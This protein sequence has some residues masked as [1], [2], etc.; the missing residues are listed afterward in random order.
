MYKLLL[1]YFTVEFNYKLIDFIVF[2]LLIIYIYL[3]ISID[4]VMYKVCTLNIA[5]TSRAYTNI[6][7]IT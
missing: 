6:S 2:I 1:N 3:L 5:V 4:F 7:Q